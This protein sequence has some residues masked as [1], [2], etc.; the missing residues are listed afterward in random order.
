[1]GI[2]QVWNQVLTASAQVH[3]IE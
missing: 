2:I 1:M 3:G